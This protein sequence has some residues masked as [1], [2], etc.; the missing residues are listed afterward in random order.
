MKNVFSSLLAI[1]ASFS[2]CSQAFAPSRSTGDCSSRAP[3]QLSA[4]ASSRRDF[5]STSIVA[6]ASAATSSLILSPLPS[7][8]DVSDGNA[9]PQGAAQFSRVI[10]VRAQLKSVAKRVAEQSSEIDKAE[11]DKIDNFLRTVYSSGEDMK[12]IAKGIYDPAKKTKADG[13][14]KLLQSLVQAAQKP[15]SNKDAAGFGVVAAKADGLFEDFFD[16]LRDI[17]DEL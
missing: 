15:V 12:V 13:D 11:W 17:P 3:T 4:T 6:A 2:P 16:L 14:I 1:S 8:A 7:V 5:L 10:K 9:L